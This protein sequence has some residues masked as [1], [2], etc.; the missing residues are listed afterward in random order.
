MRCNRGELGPQRKRQARQ[1]GGFSASSGLQYRR[2]GG[3]AAARANQA[4]KHPPMPD[5]RALT[6]S[7][8]PDSMLVEYGLRRG[9]ATAISYRCAD[10]NAVLEPLA[11][12]SGP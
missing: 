4:E 12:I 5:D 3:E 7:K 11:E 1:D 8:I 10:P 6:L 2:W 9:G